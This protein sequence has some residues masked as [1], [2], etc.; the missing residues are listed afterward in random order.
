MDENQTDMHER[1]TLLEAMLT[2]IEHRDL[3]DRIIVNSAG[4]TELYDRLSEPPLRFT[5]LQS[6]AVLSMTL[7][8]RTVDQVNALRAEIG[9]LQESRD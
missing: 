2:S 8:A 5:R 1:L 3:L 7:R 6:D 9:K 4:N